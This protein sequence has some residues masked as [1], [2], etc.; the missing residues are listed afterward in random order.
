MTDFERTMH[1]ANELAL[2][3]GG[4]AETAE[5]DTCELL[6]LA[7]RNASREMAKAIASNQAVALARSYHD[8]KAYEL[9]DAV[10]LDMGYTAGEKS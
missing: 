8:R 4:S 3:A 6:E 2:A 5:V 9:R 7:D 10:L 1:E